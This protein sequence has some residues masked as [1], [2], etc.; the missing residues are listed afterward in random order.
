MDE[1][2]EKTY[3]DI[4]AIQRRELALVESSRDV[5]RAENLRLKQK[6]KNMEKQKEETEALLRL[7]FC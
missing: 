1:N 7:V 4:L 2:D 5:D 3:S 6:I